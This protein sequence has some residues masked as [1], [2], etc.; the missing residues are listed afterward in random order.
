[1]VGDLVIY[2]L[3][4]D[5]FLERCLIFNLGMRVVV[6][7]YEPSRPIACGQHFAQD[8]V[9]CCLQRHSNLQNI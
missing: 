7:P 6:A 4:F 8:T 2:C 5:Y 9:L 3:E 1:M